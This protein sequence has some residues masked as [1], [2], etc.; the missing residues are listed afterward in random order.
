MC[1]N[2]FMPS[3]LIRMASEVKLKLYLGFF[4]SLQL[5]LALHPFWFQ[6]CSSNIW[7]LS[8]SLLL[9]VSAPFRQPRIERCK[10]IWGTHIKEL[11]GGRQFDFSMQVFHHAI[12]IQSEHLIWCEN[13]GGMKL[14][15]TEIITLW[16]LNGLQY[17]ILS[18][19]PWKLFD[20]LELIL[21]M[22]FCY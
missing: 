17:W 14:D 10:R 16:K 19:C 22:V 18:K 21:E 9:L 12:L 8:Q 11:V 5:Q 20:D 13:I 4:L 15:K 6:R 7:K 2:S 3:H 1:V